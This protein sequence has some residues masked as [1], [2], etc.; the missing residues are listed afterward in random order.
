MNT[1]AVVG[2]GAMGGRI[3]RRLAAAGH[4]LVLWNRDRAKVDALADLGPTEAESPAEAASRADAIV[5]MVR[6]PQALQDVSEGPL[7]IAAGATGPS[8]VLQLTTV[9]PPTIARL[10][11]VLPDGVGL[12]DAPVLGSLLEA[13]SGTL[14]IFAGGPPDLVS[15]W[16]PLLS[17]LGTVV[18]VGALGAGTAA[19][20]VANS[21]LFGV[22]GVLAEA[23][24]LADG[25]GLSRAVAF[26]VLAATPLAAQAERRRSAI[27]SDDYPT[28]FA[29]AL[30]RK[31]ADLIAGVAATADLDLRLA[32]AARAWL[33]D[34]ERDGAGSLDYSAVIGHVLQAGQ[35]D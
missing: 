24:A 19:K 15:R 28:R 16:T 22:L 27:E 9:D 20:L 23:L 29:L 1:V 14:K 17:D 34:A 12:L 11:S 32:A 4:E 25:L 26:E 30:A 10:A 13:E 7:G 18:P 6:D 5:V 31:D 33:A 3:A 21:T 8:T 2:L 35:R